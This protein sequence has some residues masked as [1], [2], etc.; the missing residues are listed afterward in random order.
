MIYQKRGRWCFVDKN[1]KQ[2]KF[3][4]EIEA[5]LAYGKVNAQEE[6]QADIEEEVYE[7]NSDEQEAILEGEGGSEEEV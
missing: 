5:K 1:G 6:I 4:S 3:S 7:E 2:H